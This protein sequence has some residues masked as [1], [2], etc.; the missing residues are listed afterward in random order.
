MYYVAVTD[1]NGCQNRSNGVFMNTTGVN[2]VTLNTDDIRLYPN[3][4]R[5]IIH[6]SAPVKLKVAI[7][8]L[9]GRT[10]MT[11]TSEQQID[12]RSLA[13]GVYMVQMRDMDGT[14][15]KTERLL[16]VE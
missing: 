3:P 6:I 13:K 4:T 11:A 12:L 2:T 1:V 7:Q 9:S 15:L 5:D 8:D 10:I 16:K 14:L